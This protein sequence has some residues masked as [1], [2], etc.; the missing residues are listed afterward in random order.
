MVLVPEVWKGPGNHTF[1]AVEWPCLL[2][3]LLR[4]VLRWLIQAL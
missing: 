4:G 1:S 2:F 3:T